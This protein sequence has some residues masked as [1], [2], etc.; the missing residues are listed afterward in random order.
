MELAEFLVRIKIPS[1]DEVNPGCVVYYVAAPARKLPCAWYRGKKT[2][3]LM[4][5][6]EKPGYTRENLSKHNTEPTNSTHVCT[7]KPWESAAATGH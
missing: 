2:Q 1:I 3:P 6:L 7:E 4:T 5:A